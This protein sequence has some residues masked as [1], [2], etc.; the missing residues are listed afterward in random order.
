MKAWSELELWVWQATQVDNQMKS[1]FAMVNI[2]VIDT[3]EWA[4]KFLNK[5]YEAGLDENATAGTYITTV[6]AVDKD[7]NRIEYSIVNGNAGPFKIDKY[8][9][10]IKLSGRLDYQS[11]RTYKLEIQAYDGNFSD[12]AYVSISVLNVIDKA[13]YFEKP[14]Y[15][16]KLELKEEMNLLNLFIG[17]V[18]A[19]D[20]E[21]TGK[22]NYSLRFDDSSPRRS[23]M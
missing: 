23:G 22:L 16:F 9:G 4:P 20:V 14:V 5:T 15:N 1:A 18:K 19:V 6:H 8:Q 13:P 21:M 12:T 17:Q 10:V 2:I 3:N 11:Q 7:R